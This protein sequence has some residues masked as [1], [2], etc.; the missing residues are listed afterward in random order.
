ME[1]GEDDQ[2]KMFLPGASL[3]AGHT[4]H[5]RRVWVLALV[6]GVL[7]LLLIGAGLT[8]AL[9]WPSSHPHPVSARGASSATSPPVAGVRLFEL[10]LNKVALTS[11]FAAR[12]GVQG[13][14][15][16]TIQATPMPND[17]LAL[18]L[19]LNIN[20]SGLHRVLPVEMDTTLG[21]DSQQNI[22]LT[23]Q[24]LKR[25]GLDAG[26]TAAAS[27]QDALN[28]LL[29]TTLMPA[30]HGQLKSAK[31]VAVHTS[32]T[33]ACGGSEEMLVLL[34]A[35]QPTPTALCFAQPVDLKKLLPG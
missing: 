3:A 12:L 15:L 18:T 28:Q 17:G 34:I 35:A 27:M 19:N 32:S 23:I 14:T 29:F 10:A 25:D 5:S 31:L 2:E 4:G 33:V 9:F 1:R 21:L 13:G 24:H 26:P 20:A 7:V 11:I 30:L 6:A 22:T 16:S 8:T